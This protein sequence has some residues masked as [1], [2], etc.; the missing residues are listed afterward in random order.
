MGWST[1]SH[2][3]ARCLAV[4]KLQEVTETFSSPNK[5]KCQ[6]RKSRWD[7]KENDSGLRETDKNNH[8]E[9]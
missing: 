7:D 6:Q 4:P 8:M 2:K 3:E 9:W 5:M 1:L